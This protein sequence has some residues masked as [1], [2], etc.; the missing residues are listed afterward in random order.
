MAVDQAWCDAW[1]GVSMPEDHVCE[2]ASIS[3]WELG[4]KSGMERGSERGS[5]VSMSISLENGLEEEFTFAGRDV[6]TSA[7]KT[8]M[9][10]RLN[11]SSLSS[12]PAELSSSSETAA[13]CGTLLVPPL[14]KPWLVCALLL[15]IGPVVDMES[16]S[17]VAART[18]NL[19]PSAPFGFLDALRGLYPAA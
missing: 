18:G 15:L 6:E 13:L 11:T 12:S 1:I 14:N 3:D 2:C 19:A 10:G 16:W 4:M 7:T 8:G 17:S 5:M 9:G